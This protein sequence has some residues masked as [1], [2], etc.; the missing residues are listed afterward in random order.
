M[1]RLVC[2]LLILL[3]AHP[4]AAQQT[5]PT[6]DELGIG[7]GRWMMFGPVFRTSPTPSGLREDLPFAAAVVAGTLSNPRTKP[8]VTDFRVDWVV[9]TH[10]ALKGK[11]VLAL[12]RYIEVK[13]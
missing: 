8:D 3:A 13:D 5:P 1:S 6:L 7:E 10:P 2:P 12:P 9:K 4:V 11:P